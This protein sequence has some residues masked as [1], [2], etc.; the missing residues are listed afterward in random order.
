M[1]SHNA[2]KPTGGASVRRVMEPPAPN[3]PLAGEHSLPS[4]GSVG[5]VNRPVRTRMLGGVWAGG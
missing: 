5:S 1:N 4:Y 3:D 2:K